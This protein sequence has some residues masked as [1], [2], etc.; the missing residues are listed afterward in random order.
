MFAGV[1]TY[2]SS[3]NLLS[4]QI[5][6]L[7]WQLQFLLQVLYVQCVWREGKRYREP[8]LL[9]LSFMAMEQMA[10]MCR[11]HVCVVYIGYVWT[12]TYKPLCLF[13]DMIWLFA[14]IV[15]P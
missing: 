7:K 1:C 8:L 10:G 12:T 2:R 15:W 13:I 5:M 6:I 14:H 11:V 4:N 9:H 3:D